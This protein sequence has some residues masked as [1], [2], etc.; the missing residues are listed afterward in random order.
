ME[1][2]IEKKN[3]FETVLKNTNSWM[4]IYVRIHTNAMHAYSQRHEAVITTRNARLAAWLSVLLFKTHTHTHM[5]S[6]AF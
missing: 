6:R 1:F 4:I 2:A 5:H 3:A